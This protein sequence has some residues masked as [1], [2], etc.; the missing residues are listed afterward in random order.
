MLK[1]YF[2]SL[3]LIFPLLINAQAVTI[4]ANQ[5]G[6]SVQKEMFG[7]NIVYTWSNFDQLD[8]IENQANFSGIRFP[9]GSVTENE[10]NL[11]NPDQYLSFDSAGVVP[12]NKTI[13]RFIEKVNQYNWT[14]IFVLPTKR[15]VNQEIIGAS[16][17]KQYVKNILQG[18]YGNISQNRTI[19]FEIGNEFFWGNDKIT[20]SEYGKVALAHISAI[21]EAISESNSTY[22]IEI[23]VQ[24]GTTDDEAKAVALEFHNQPQ[25]S[26]IDFLTWHWYPGRTEIQ[27]GMWNFYGKN[28]TLSER[29]E[30]IRTQWVN[31]A[32]VNVPFFLSEYNIRNANNSTFDH[33]LKN[34]MGVMSIFAESV[35]ANTTMT[36]IWPTI[37]AKSLRTRLY[38]LN[39]TPTFNGV[40]YNWMEQYIQNK[41]IVNGIQNNTYTNATSFRSQGAYVQAFVSDNEMVIFVHGTEH[42]K[43]QFRIDVEGFE[44]EKRK[45]CRMLYTT[46]GQ[47][48]NPDAPAKV[49]R[50]WP[51]I[52]GNGS[53]LT[54]T[55]NRDSK[56]EVARIVLK[57]KRTSIEHTTMAMDSIVLPTSKQE[58]AELITYPNPASST[59]MIQSSLSIQTID[60][61]DKSGIV[62]NQYDCNTANC[63]SISVNDLKEG[64]Y[65]IRIITTEGEV[66]SKSFIKQ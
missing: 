12:E 4:N 23:S 61:L 57:G 26:A 27:L 46:A 8:Q 1:K 16:E 54:F 28:V 13:G 65:Y 31:H 14:A 36:T 51:K 6:R 45:A 63:N 35:R 7:A 38:N 39:A 59:L 19:H 52:W 11:L 29:L 15:Y 30:D 22:K 60:V 34:P 25:A 47:E 18:T 43:K 37:S 24:S 66:V 20:G 44:I 32:Q 50:I 56:Y 62:L 49:R 9:G 58:E 2:L 3:F 10:L 40:Y 33:G 42:G 17:V 48:N 64:L 41:Q 5:A 53:K 55:L 21:E